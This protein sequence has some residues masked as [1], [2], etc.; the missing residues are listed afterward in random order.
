MANYVK[1]FGAFYINRCFLELIL[2]SPPLYSVCLHHVSRRKMSTLSQTYY[3]HPQKDSVF[4][5][6]AKY[7]TI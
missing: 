7:I 5:L 3:S 6:H 4:L 1:K 2:S